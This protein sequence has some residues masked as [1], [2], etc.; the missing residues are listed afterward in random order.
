MKLL[1]KTIK[2]YTF[3]E[4]YNKTS[5]DKAKSSVLEIENPP[6]FFSEDLREMLF[7]V[8][9]LR[10][11]RTYFS[12][13]FSQGDGLCL[14]GK[15]TFSELFENPKF[16]QIAFKGLH[17]RQV[18]SIYD[19]LYSIKFEHSGRYFYAN[20]VSMKSAVH[21][22]T[23]KQAAIIGKVVCN[24][25]KWYFS[26]CSDWEKRG[27]TYFYDISDN[28]M[29]CICSDSGYLFT[30]QGTIIDQKEYLELSA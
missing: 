13:S 1:S 10:N 16:K 27:Y 11:L 19:Q 14:H 8:Y 25:K 2:G 26:F 3:S 21:D 9:G 22:P 15:I 28:D 6:E 12:L 7:E 24:I 29:E 18:Y 20:S 30:E 17:H 4:L 23:E 5:R